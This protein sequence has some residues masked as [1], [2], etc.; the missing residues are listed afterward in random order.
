LR[1]SI[2]TE[3]ENAHCLSALNTVLRAEV[4]A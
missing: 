1:I 4:A 2:G 3:A